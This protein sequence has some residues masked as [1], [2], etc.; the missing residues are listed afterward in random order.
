MKI[1]YKTSAVSTGGRDGKVVVENSPL[2]FDM[3][4]PAE[5]GGR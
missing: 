1:L 3:A 5:L 4:L 2:E